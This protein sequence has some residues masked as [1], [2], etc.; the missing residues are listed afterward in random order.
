MKSYLERFKPLEMKPLQG[1]KDLSRIAATPQ[2][3]SGSCR[4]R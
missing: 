2:R 4:G 1:L 3:G